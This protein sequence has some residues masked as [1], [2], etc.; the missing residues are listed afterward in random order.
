[1][2]LW[3]SITRLYH[4]FG[5]PKYFYQLSG[6]L[7][8]WFIGLTL[9][10]LLPGLIWGLGF[11]PI[12]E[13]QGHSYRIIFIHVPAA[14]VA[15]GGYVVM[16]MAA[17]VGLIWK[18]KMADMMAKAIAP[19]G[20]SFAFLCLVTGSI[21]GKPTWGTWWVW[22]A[23]LTS[24]LVLFFLYLGFIALQNAIENPVSAAKAS[25]ILAIVGVVNLPIIKYSV[26]WWNTLHQPATIKVIG[27]STIDPSML[28]PLLLSIT[29]FYC[30]FGLLVLLGARNEVLQREQRSHW[31]QQEVTR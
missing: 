20:A 15:M 30:L 16:A 17:A 2:S 31:V 21:W 25:G 29:G 5:S 24:M 9:L 14:G 19:I 28:Y 4:K 13:E 18:M 7:L 22:D 8:P 1:M 23:R 6:T 27:E 12:D 3:D 11:A 10:T 26:N